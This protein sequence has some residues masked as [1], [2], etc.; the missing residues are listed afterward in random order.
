[1]W[2]HVIFFL[3]FSS[4][5]IGNILDDDI[6]DRAVIWNLG[7]NNEPELILQDLRIPSSVEM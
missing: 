7:K 5:G 6:T 2:Y 1:M 3:S 4:F